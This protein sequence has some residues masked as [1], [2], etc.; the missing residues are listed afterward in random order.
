MTYDSRP[1][2]GATLFCLFPG[3]TRTRIYWL[4][5]GRSEVPLT[6]LACAGPTAGEV[7]QL[8]RYR[9]GLRTHAIRSAH[10]CVLVVDS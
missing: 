8:S 6:M 3:R 10:C 4:W 5:L 2:V 7:A 1:L 9:I